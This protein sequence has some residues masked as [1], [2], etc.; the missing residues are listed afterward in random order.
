VLPERH[1]QVD[2]G[3][4]LALLLQVDDLDDELLRHVGHL[5]EIAAPGRE[6][7]AG[8]LDLDKYGCYK[9][10]R[11]RNDLSETRD[12]FSSHSTLKQA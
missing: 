12:K 1:D 4:G 8:H 6:G 2:E 5:A 10:G 9:E 3:A 7:H 11:D